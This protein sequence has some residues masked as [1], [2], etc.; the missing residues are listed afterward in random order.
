MTMAGVL[1]FYI[2][3]ITETVNS[4]ASDIVGRIVVSV[5]PEDRRAGGRSVHRLP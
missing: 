5:A 3:F 2:F 4:A 1:T